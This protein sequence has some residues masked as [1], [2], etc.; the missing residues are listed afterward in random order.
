ME[1]TGQYCRAVWNIL[2][3]E[4]PRLVLVN[5]THVKA[6]AGRKTDR[7]DSKR[8]ARVGHNQAIFSVA[9]QILRI[10]YMMLKCGEDYRELGSY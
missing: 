5:P 10:A 4:V 3:G 2:E 7:I 1:S 6:L 8:P 9:H